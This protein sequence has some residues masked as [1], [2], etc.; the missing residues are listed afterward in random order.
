MLPDAAPVFAKNR[1]LAD[2]PPEIIDMILLQARDVKL[3]NSLG[4]FW[5]IK[6]LM[7]KTFEK[8]M[9]NRYID[10]LVS[11]YDAMVQKLKARPANLVD[12][13]ALFGTIEIFEI[14]N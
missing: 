2:L 7:P 6:K 9:G 10:W 3:A 8:A 11:C 1:E 4:R 14:F 13:A 12:W 5:L